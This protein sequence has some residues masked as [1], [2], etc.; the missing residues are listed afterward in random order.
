MMA[1]EHT[2]QAADQAADMKV[3]AAVVD[4]FAREVEAVIELL[5]RPGWDHAMVAGQLRLIANVM[6]DPQFRHTPY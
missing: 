1:T 2:D 6:R 4:V 3:G 5:D